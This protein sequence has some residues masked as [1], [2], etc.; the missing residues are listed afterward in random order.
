MTVPLIHF[1]QVSY[2]INDD[3]IP[4]NYVDLTPPATN[5]LVSLRNFVEPFDGSDP[6]F[7][8]LNLQNIPAKDIPK[9]F[10]PT[11][12][13]VGFNTITLLAW[14]RDDPQLVGSSNKVRVVAG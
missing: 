2:V 7:G 5:I 9:C 1:Y 4:L 6:H 8:S 3:C 14:D 12:L 11:I 10:T 13:D